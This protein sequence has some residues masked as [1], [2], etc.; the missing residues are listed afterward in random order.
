M[1]GRRARHW[2]AEECR[3]AEQERSG[4]ESSPGSPEPTPKVTPPPGF[5]GVAVCLLRESPLSAPIEATPE[6]RQLAMLEEPAVT[7]MYDTRKV[8][9]EVTGVTYMDTV[10][11]S[12]GRVALGNPC[13]VATF[14]GAT[15]EELAEEDLAES[16][17]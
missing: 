4:S 13:M 8:Q 17:P 14:P 9:D 12:V 11:A 3:Q 2:R 6:V 10:T 16:R 5:K 15:L 1:G 7:T